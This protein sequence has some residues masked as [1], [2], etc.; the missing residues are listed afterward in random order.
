MDTDYV[1]PRNID[2]PV[3][4]IISLWMLKE[5]TTYLTQICYKM[6]SIPNESLKE[7]PLKQSATVNSTTQI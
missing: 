6:K 7:N 2:I 5:Q 1:Y 3:T 4:R